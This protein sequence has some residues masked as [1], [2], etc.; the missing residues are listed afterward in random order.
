MSNPEY[1]VYEKAEN[2]D[3]GFSEQQLDLDSEIQAGEWER[4]KNH[5]TYQQRSRQ[6]KI[7]ATH[8]AIN[9]RITQLTVFYYKLVANNPQHGQKMLEE[10]KS[11]RIMLSVLEQC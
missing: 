4:L 1:E 11:L 7:I 6:W 8:K 5:R 2:T 9:N 10:L 3:E